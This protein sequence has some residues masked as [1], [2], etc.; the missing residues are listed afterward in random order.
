MAD[1]DSP[2]DTAVTSARVVFA[3]R[4]LLCR[5]AWKVSLSQVVAAWALARQAS[6]RVRRLSCM[7]LVYVRGVVLWNLRRH[8]RR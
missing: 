7:V 8:V 4:P 6:P 5:I 1:Q 3:D 2:T